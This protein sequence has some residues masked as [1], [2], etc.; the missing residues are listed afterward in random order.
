MTRKHLAKL[1]MVCGTVLCLWILRGCC[2]NIVQEH[3]TRA[4][5]AWTIGKSRTHASWAIGQNKLTELTPDSPYESLFE[6]D[7]VTSTFAGE[8]IVGFWEGYLVIG[9][10]EDERQVIRDIKVKTMHGWF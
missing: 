8:R 10:V 1:K 4:K 2:W 3:Q 5:Y 6:G 7:R 9:F